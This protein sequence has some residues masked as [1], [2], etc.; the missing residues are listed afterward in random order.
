MCSDRAQPGETVKLEVKFSS[1]D[2]IRDKDEILLK[3]WY[4]RLSWD[5]IDTFDSN[6]INIDKPDDYAKAIGCRLNEKTGYY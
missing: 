6:R 2:Q 5:G 3:Y 4:P 1:G